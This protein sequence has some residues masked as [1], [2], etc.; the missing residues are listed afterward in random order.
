M[1]RRDPFVLGFAVAGGLLVLF[2][3]LPLGVSVL[4][5]SPV[6]VWTTLADREVLVSLGLT[7]YA[8]AAATLI[9][10]LSG[11]PLAYLLARES[12]RGKRLIEGLID[13]PVVIPHTAAGIAL[14]M[15]FG[16]RG[17]VG[18]LTEPFGVRFTDS[19]AGIVVGML[20]VSLPFLVNGAREAFALVDPE[21]ELIAQTEGATRW[22]AFRLVTLPLAL[23]GIL[24]GA[25]M[26]WARGISEFGAVVIIAYHPQ[27]VPV[28]VFERLQG[29]GLDAA[30]PVA[31][32]LILGAL[33]IFSLLRAVV[34]PHATSH[35]T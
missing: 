26:M 7:F 27:I 19:T 8:G 11:I 22:Q 13:L 14:L 23:R 25:M 35:R 15:V 4:G 34:M 6:M 17:P 16:R 24:A 3:L 9:A 21:L 2:V 28:L 31:V 33:V 12:F 30:R 20:F 32:I 1:K 5:T 18:R 29:F 10:M